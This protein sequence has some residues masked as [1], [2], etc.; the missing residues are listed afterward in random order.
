MEEEY[1]W[2]PIFIRPTLDITILVS[3]K[4]QKRQMQCNLK[5]AATVLNSDTSLMLII[6]CVILWRS[7]RFI[8]L[9]Q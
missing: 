4:K 3:V 7:D 8:V 6:E 1:I 5:I 2:F 9:Q